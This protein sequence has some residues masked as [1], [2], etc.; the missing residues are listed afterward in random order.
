MVRNNGSVLRKTPDG[1]RKRSNDDKWSFG[2]QDKN[3][4]YMVFSG[5]R[6]HRIVAAAFHGIPD[7]SQMVVDHIDTNRA[8]NRPD[9]LRWVTKVENVLLNPI[10]CKRIEL[11]YGSLDA[12]FADPGKYR[13]SSGRPDI[14]W[15]RTVSRAEAAAAK[16]RLEQWAQSGKVPSG[17]ALGEW[18][19][20]VDEP[21]PDNVT[22]SLTPSSKQVDWRVP[23]TFPLCP[24]AIDEDVLDNY[25]EQ[26]VFG[27][28][29]AT[30]NYYTS[31]VVQADMDADNIHILTN[32]KNGVKQWA[33]AQVFVE[34][35][36]VFHKSMGTFFTL[37][38]ALKT[39]CE[40]TQ[41]E[42]DY[43]IDDDM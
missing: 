23:T 40:Y 35:R 17:G 43:S 27:E 30:N 16:E 6:V 32:S 15:M 19:F 29:F 33:N 13:A 7:D 31:K 10:T 21:M 11:A 22:P 20:Q 41:T 8:N 34:N 12:F 14:D 25:Y 3:H 36:V 38:G 4:G 2:I 28:V 42:F 37:Q 5:V 39:F 26:L 1:K 24:G 18:L 9:N